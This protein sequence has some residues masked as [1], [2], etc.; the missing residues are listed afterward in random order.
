MEHW[1]LRGRPTDKALLLAAIQA[2]INKKE[3]EKQEKKV[4]ELPFDTKYKYSATLHQLDKKRKII[5]LMGAPEIIFEKAK[6]ENQK[7]VQSKNEEFTSKGYRVLAF[8]YKKVKNSIKKLADKDL[9]D[10][11]FAGLVALHDPLRET[12]KSAILTSYKAGMRPI[13]VT[14]DHK[15]TAK[16]V[17]EKIGLKI[18]DKNILEG[19]EFDKLSDQ[20]FGK[21]FEDISLYARVSPEQKLRIIQAWQDKGEVV[22]MTGEGINDALALKKAN[23]GVALGSG[24]EIAKEASDLILLTDDF[25]I[26]VVAVEEGRRITD[27][28]RKILTYLLTGGFTELILIGLAVLFRLPLPVLA[29]QILWKNLIES[30]PPSM[31]LTFEPKEKDIM[32]RRPESSRSPLL[33]K[34]MKFLIFVIGMTTNLLLFGIFLWFL[35]SPNYG[36]EKIDKIR[37]VIF[38]GL[39]I[40]SFF[41]IFSFRSL[42]KNI[43]Q[44]NPFSNIYIN[45]T[46][47]LGF[48]LLIMAI[49]LP[50]FQKFL[51]TQALNIFELSLLIAFA[52]ISVI[53]IEAAKFYWIRVSPLQK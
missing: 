7:E 34:E 53:L 39:A 42:R 23:I 40:D 27:N 49:Y 46:S 10:M 8:A 21:I 1:I 26:I 15:L 52:F 5:Y 28:I 48:L 36:M 11:V 41:S 9:E 47:V 22:A 43:W 29:G 20:E 37:T 14:G 35:Y 19:K 30:T 3:V 38:A 44:Y 50:F 25:E 12:A 13:I 17:A 16:A 51:Q 4:D 6:I 31:A 45:L 32:L 18:T 24:T 2:G 33:N